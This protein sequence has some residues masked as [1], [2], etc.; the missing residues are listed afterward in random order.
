MFVEFINMGE[1]DL[2]VDGVKED[3]WSKM[4]NSSVILV[5]LTIEDR[6]A[7]GTEWITL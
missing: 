4:A 6:R 3:T 2:G 5:S 1:K 7:E